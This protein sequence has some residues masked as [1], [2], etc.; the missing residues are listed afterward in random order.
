MEF[1]E[2][3]KIPNYA[4]KNLV[5]IEVGYEDSIFQSMFNF[6]NTRE[7]KSSFIMSVQSKLDI[8]LES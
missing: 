2:G 1:A 7:S 3:L 8:W 6:R 5:R 4:M